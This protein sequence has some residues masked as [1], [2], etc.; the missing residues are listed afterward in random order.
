MNNNLL[1][2]LNE[3]LSSVDISNVDIESQNQ[4]SKVNLTVELKSILKKPQEK[5]DDILS[6][7]IIIKI[8]IALIVLMIMSPIAVCDLYFGFSD[9]TCSR[10]EKDNSNIN[11]RIY[12]I[13]TGFIGIAFTIE[14]LMVIIWFEAYKSSRINDCIMFYILIGTIFVAIFNFIWTILGA[15]IFW[16]FIYENGKCSKTFS[17][18]LFVSLIVKFIFTLLP[19]IFKINKE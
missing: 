10:E 17:N 4:E 19:L 15:V 16:G 11:L 9:S 18:Y 12:L 1:I 6:K 14:M 5:T 7:K 3:R 8:C 13:V 2:D